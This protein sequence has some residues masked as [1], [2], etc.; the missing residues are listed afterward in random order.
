MIRPVSGV[1][2]RD[3]PA[4]LDYAADRTVFPESLVKSLGLPQVG[5]IQLGAFGGSVYTSPVYAVLLGVHDLPPSPMVVAAN[6][7]ESWILLG[8]D[9]LNSHRVILDGPRLTLEIDTSP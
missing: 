6:S 4:Q 2:A 8:R 1:E 3:V 7:E 5:A 9:V